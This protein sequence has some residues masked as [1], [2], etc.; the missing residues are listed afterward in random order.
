MLNRIPSPQHL[1]EVCKPGQ[2]TKTCR[3]LQTG[4]LN[5]PTKKDIDEGRGCA[6]N[7]SD[8]LDQEM[9]PR[10][11]VQIAKSDNCTGKPNFTPQ[12]ESSAA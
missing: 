6:K 3:F 5:G 1:R 10:R 12:C 8:T 7:V 11:F 4:D 2:L 9:E